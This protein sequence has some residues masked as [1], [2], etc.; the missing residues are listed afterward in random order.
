MLNI[1]QQYKWLNE[2]RNHVTPVK[3]SLGGKVRKDCR[4]GSLFFFYCLG[5]LYSVVWDVCSAVWD[6]RSVAWDIRST[7]WNINNAGTELNQ[8]A[9]A[10]LA[11]T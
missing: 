3:A 10:A 9:H 2:P 7:A 1:R 11:G 8:T 6:V 4:I 5:I